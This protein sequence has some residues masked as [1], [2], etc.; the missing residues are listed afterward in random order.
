MNSGI[1]IQQGFPDVLRS[2]AAALYDA[3]FGSKLSIAIPDTNQ[4]IDFLREGFRPDFC[5]VAMSDSKLVGIAGF[6]TATGGFH[7]ENAF[8]RLYA[9]LGLL[10]A[11]RA[12]VVLLFF[13]RKCEN[14]QLL[15]DGI[16]VAPE[17]RGSDI[18]SSLLRQLQ[19]HARIGGYHT[20]L[21]EV[22][23]T[24]PA[25]RRLYERLGFVAT[26]KTSFNYLRGLLGF[27][28]AITMEYPVYNSA[29]VGAVTPLA[30][31]CKERKA[32]NG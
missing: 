8:V 15:I 24:N 9:Q 31:P 12:S 3:A 25:A 26:G 10:G 1:T 14:G 6:N 13:E 21:L 2:E 5:F 19:E 20:L 30:T 23:D 17:K 7:E 4:R 22:I 29:S 16:S 18:G 11:I 27:G 32:L 28:A